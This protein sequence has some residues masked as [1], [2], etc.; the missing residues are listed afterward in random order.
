M[1]MFNKPAIRRLSATL[2]ITMFLS[3]FIT[4]AEPVS[5]QFMSGGSSISVIGS[6]IP[7]LSALQNQL[8]TAQNTLTTL[9]KIATPIYGA[10]VPNNMEAMS[11]AQRVKA[12]LGNAKDVLGENIAHSGSFAG[13]ASQSGQAA[14]APMAPGYNDQ[15]SLGLGSLGKTASGILTS[16]PASE[17]IARL[18][19]AIEAAKIALNRVIT[20]TRAR[21]FAVGQ[22][23]GLID[24]NKIFEDGK[25]I[26]KSESKYLNK[27][28]DGIFSKLFKKEAP[29]PQKP[30]FTQKLSTG[31][32]GG[33]QAAKDSLKTSF[34]PENLIVTAAVAV[35][36][37]LAIDVIHGQKPSLKTAVKQ[38]ASLEFA[39]NVVG[40]AIGAAG[41]QFT[42]TL[43]K[44][45]VPGIAG[46]L[47]G[48]VVP[49]MFA[50][51]SGQ[52]GANLMT[53]LKN[54][55]FSIRKAFEKIDKADL[56]G[57]SIGSTIGMTLGT[58]IPIPYVGTIL[59]GMVG[60][61]IGSKV[62]RWVS[63]L[64]GKNKK[65][66]DLKTPA[67]VV[68]PVLPSAAEINTYGVYQRGAQ[69]PSS[70]VAVEASRGDISS[71]RL[72]Q[73]LKETEENYYKA[74]LE[75]NRRVS[76]NDMEGAK[77]VF[78]DL[79]RFSDDYSLLKRALSA[80]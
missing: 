20:A 27:K 61:M 42:A 79:Q 78:K 75:Y 33:V 65:V 36:T 6:A 22:R 15:M 77:A 31:I 44:T 10:V 5:A 2:A 67:P 55:E 57:S 63:G 53:G 40:S 66:A 54:G 1:S 9:E 72:A 21:V 8:T 34:S 58:M 56:I 32:S 41:G 30:T 64:F 68:D 24:Q 35:G 73:L 13:Q 4:T 45:F 38:V 37:N 76:A 60:G 16:G 74:Y 19:P 59:G 71:D 17:I 46:Q 28:K 23:V 43:V 26:D 7:E 69:A 48:A 50:S 11:V 18:K 12:I 14:Q 39:G 70:N 3:L 80:N 25:V 52:V 51:A 29:E 49:V 47:I 62:A